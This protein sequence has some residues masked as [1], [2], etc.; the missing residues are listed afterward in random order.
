MSLIK[1]LV[2]K[3][4]S[5][6]SLT[7][8]KGAENGPVKS[9]AE[10]FAPAKRGNSVSKPAKVAK[11]PSRD[12]MT[13]E[14]RNRD[15]LLGSVFC[16]CRSTALRTVR[17]IRDSMDIKQWALFYA[18]FR[19]TGDRLFWGLRLRLRSTTPSVT[20]APPIRH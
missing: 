9:I 6:P 1:N 19:K 5:S 11:M 14:L 12:A 15:V 18:I 7:T 20:K 10:R 16:N 2:E 3:R 13:F 8:R 17:C 4:G